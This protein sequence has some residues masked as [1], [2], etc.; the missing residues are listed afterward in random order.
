MPLNYKGR[1][2]SLFSGDLTSAFNFAEPD[3]SVPTMPKPRKLKEP[4][5][6]CSPVLSKYPKTRDVPRQPSGKAKRPSGLAT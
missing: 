2:K 5:V 6:V 1:L 4:G 3:L